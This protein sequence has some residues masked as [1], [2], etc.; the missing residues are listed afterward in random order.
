YYDTASLT[1][2]KGLSNLKSIGGDLVIQ[3]N[4]GL[5][6]LEG[7]NNLTSINGYVLITNHDLL[8][9]LD[10]LSNI[11]TINIDLI[12]RNNGGLTSLGLTELSAVDGNLKIYNNTQLPNDLAVSLGSQAVIGG[13]TSIYGNQE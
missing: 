3:E 4:D 13:E 10:A 1:N 9:S 6:S 2:I 5:T 8:T 12:I 11:E 7:L